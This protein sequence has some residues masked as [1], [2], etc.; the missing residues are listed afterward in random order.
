MVGVLALRGRDFALV[1]LCRHGCIKLNGS[2]R[3]HFDHP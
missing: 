2:A 1:V 3:N